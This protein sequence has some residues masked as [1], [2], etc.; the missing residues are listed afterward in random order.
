MEY[1]K[2]ICLNNG[3]LI[4]KLNIKNSYFLFYLPIVIQFGLNKLLQAIFCQKC[5][6]DINVISVLN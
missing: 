6:Q 5:N 1:S 3:R 2:I 4:S